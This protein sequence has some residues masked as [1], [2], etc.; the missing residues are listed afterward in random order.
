MT[1]AASGYALQGSGPADAPVISANGIVSAASYTGGAIS[2]GELISIFGVNFGAN[3]LDLLTSATPNNSLPFALGRT[4]VFFNGSPGAITAATANQ[5]NVFVPPS[6][7]YAAN[8]VTVAVE[9]DDA[10]SLSVSVPLAASAPGLFTADGSGSGQGAIL[11]QDS[12]INSS[13]HPAARGSIVSLFGTGEGLDSPQLPAGALVISTPYP[14]P[15]N[16]ATV[17]IGGQ[18]AEVLYAGAAPLLPTGVFQINARIP[19]SVSTGKVPVS[20]SIG[21]AGTTRQVTIAVE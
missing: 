1:A 6:V 18:P 7:L 11:N 5:I 16:A 4:K 13:A 10:I 17:S 14:A 9:V 21:R 3:N 15:L 20:I 12:S 19:E 8:P 2:A